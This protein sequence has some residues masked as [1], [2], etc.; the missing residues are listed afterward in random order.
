MKRIVIAAAFAIALP[1]SFASAAGPFDGQ[2]TGGAPPVRLGGNV[3]CKE[4]TATVSVVNGKMTGKFTDQI[5]SYS[6][7]A[8]VA[9]DGTVSGLWAAYPLSGKFSGTHFDG[10]YTSKECGNTVRTI[11]LN[12][13][14]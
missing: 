9:A 14:G 1:V 3:S 12:K 7:N 11:S 5:H 13:S 10:T 4:T 2:Y 6:I 8:T